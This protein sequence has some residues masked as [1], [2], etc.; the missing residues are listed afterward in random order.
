MLRSL[1]HTSQRD[2]AHFRLVEISLALGNSGDAL[3]RA[4]TEVRDRPGSA[5]AWVALSE[6]LRHRGNLAGADQAL[7]RARALDPEHGWV[8]WAIESAAERQGRA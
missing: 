4:E 7:E 8:R 5:V 6:A 3:Q 1:L 2:N